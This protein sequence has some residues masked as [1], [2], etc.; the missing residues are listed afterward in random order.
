MLLIRDWTLWHPQEFV[1][2]TKHYR[3]EISTPALPTVNKIREEKRSLIDDSTLSI[4]EPCSPY[5]ST[6]TLVSPDGDVVTNITKICG[7]KIPLH[8]LRQ[9]MLEQQKYM[10]LWSDKDIAKLTTDEALTFVR[11][12]HYTPESDATLA[13]LHQLVASVQRTRAIA[14]W[15]DHS[16]ILKQGYILFAMWVVYDPAVFLSESEYYHRAKIAVK[17][18]QT[19]GEQPKIYMI[20]P[21]TSSPSDQLS[22][23]V[24]RVEC[25]HEPSEKPVCFEW[26][27]CNFSAATNQLNNPRGGHKLVVTIHVV[28]VDA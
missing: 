19:I 20:A 1:L 14:L 4:G 10:R 13:E 27:H 22:L 6:R 25:L 26:D 2:Y 8:Y 28:H 7:R 16:T 3:G 18:I 23:T 5:D 17:N 24:D 15:H 9:K 11:D 21:C 12:N